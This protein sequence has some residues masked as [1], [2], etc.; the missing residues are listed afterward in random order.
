MGATLF[1]LTFASDGALW[2]AGIGACGREL[3]MRYDT[4]G[5]RTA[6]HLAFA[7]GG[8]ATAIVPGNAGQVWA[9]VQ[10]RLG[11]TSGHCQVE[12][13]DASGQL[14]WRIQLSRP[15]WMTLAGAGAGRLVAA[16]SAFNGAGDIDGLVEQLDVRNSPDGYCTAQVNSLGCTPAL[17][18]AGNSSASATSGFVVS[19]SRVLN[20]KS[21]LFFYGTSGVA[22]VPFHGGTRCV[23]GPLHRSA[24]LNSGGGASPVNDCSGV[25]AL[26][27]NAFASN[28]PALSQ[29]GTTVYVQAWSHDP[30]A[31]STT[32]LSSALHFVVLP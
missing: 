12:Q 32:N 24:L 20:Q 30:A 31:P 13:F 16:G 28:S 27:F 17:I 9:S 23:A 26:D 3:V 18:F 25:L 22:S 14:N 8:Y 6:T 29:P 7:R 19:V 21:G 5:T 2:A 1:D 4:S 15:S 10:H 11:I